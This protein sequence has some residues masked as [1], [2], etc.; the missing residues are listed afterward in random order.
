[1]HANQD[2]FLA[3][4]FGRKGSN[5][6]IANVTFDNAPISLTFNDHIH[7]FPPLLPFMYCIYSSMSVITLTRVV[8]QL[9]RGNRNLPSLLMG[10]ARRHSY[11]DN[12]PS[13]ILI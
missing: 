12:L 4:S 5:S 1:M 2:I 10:Y 3:D 7:M 8:S 13:P 9:A 6:V 11:M